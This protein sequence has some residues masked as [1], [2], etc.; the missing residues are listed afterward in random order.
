MH[1]TLVVAPLRVLGILVVCLL[2]CSCD[3]GSL[4]VFVYVYTEIFEILDF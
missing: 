1:L 2:V 4:K 3:F